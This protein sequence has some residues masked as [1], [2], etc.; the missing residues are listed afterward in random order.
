MTTNAASTH[1]SPS[2]SAV[3]SLSGLIGRFCMTLPEAESELCAAEAAHRFNSVRRR[4]TP[5]RLDEET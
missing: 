1:Q 3:T 5:R 2:A 4:G